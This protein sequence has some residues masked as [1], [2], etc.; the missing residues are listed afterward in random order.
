MKTQ[1]ICYS[2]FKTKVK[3]DIEAPPLLGSSGLQLEV[4]RL[5]KKD[6]EKAAEVN[7]LLFL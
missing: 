4:V 6:Q 7:T 2:E 3:F 5:N 1:Y